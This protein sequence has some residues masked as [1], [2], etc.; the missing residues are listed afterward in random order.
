MNGRS[1]VAVIFTSLIALAMAHVHSALATDSSPAVKFYERASTYLNQGDLPHALADYSEAIRLD[2]TNALYYNDR[3]IVYQVMRDYDHALADYS[4]AI[5]IDPTY[6]TAY[7]NRGMLYYGNNEYDRAIADHERAI[8]INPKSSSA[9]RN[10]GNAHRAIGQLDRAIADYSQAIE[11]DPKDQ[12]SYFSRGRLHLYVGALTKAVDDLTRASELA[13]TDVYV[14]LWLDI[15]L[16]R[17]GEPRMASTALSYIDKS[18]W[19]APLLRLYLDQRTPE[20]VLAAARTA[21]GDLKTREVCEAEF[22]GGEFLLGRNKKAEATR[23]FRLAI[24]EC[25]P[26]YPEFEGASE[27]LKA[28]GVKP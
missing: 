16:Q 10:L 4:K 1:S 8:K 23:M 24:A 21:E 27:E 5:E 26:N 9:Y 7:N 28:L 22:Y 12:R 11:A 17:K 13:P 2:T 19:P 15:A 14:E 25:P 20:D 6:V 18:L 3:G